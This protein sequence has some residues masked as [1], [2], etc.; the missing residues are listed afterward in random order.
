M[1]IKFNCSYG[2]KEV[3]VN[4]DN[5]LYANEVLQETQP[6]LKPKQ[7]EITFVNGRVIYVNESIEHLEKKISYER[8]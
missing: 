8:G 1:N 5:V 7:M 4:W 6:L 2:K 3:L